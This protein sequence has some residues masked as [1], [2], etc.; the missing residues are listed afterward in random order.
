MNNVA[1][2]L[3]LAL[4]LVHV[5]V[6]A[7]ARPPPTR[8]PTPPPPPP[9]PAA[10]AANCFLLTAS[11]SCPEFAGKSKGSYR[12]APQ[13]N[14]RN[15]TEF[16]AF[17]AAN[18]PTAPPF[19]P[20]FRQQYSCPT[21]D[22]TGL[23]YSKTFTCGLLVSA[24]T[25]ACNP[26]V[27]VKQVCM[28][29][30]RFTVQSY[31]AIFNNTAFCPAGT[32]R[33]LQA[34]FTAYA[35]SLTRNDPTT[36][37]VI[38]LKSELPMCGWSSKG[39]V[40]NYCTGPGS[41]DPCCVE[42]KLAGNIVNPALT[43][44][45]TTAIV[46]PA[47]TTLSDMAATSTAQAAGTAPAIPLI[48]GMQPVQLG[49][50]IAVAGVVLSLVV[51]AVFTVVRARSAK[52]DNDDR[53]GELGG[54]YFSGPDGFQNK[55][56]RGPP[57][58]MDGPRGRGPAPMPKPPPPQPAAVA[59]KGRPPM[60]GGGDRG[61]RGGPK[62][63]TMEVAYEYIPHLDDEIELRPGDRVLVKAKFDD[64]W[65]TGVN[66]DSREEGSFP[67]DCLVPVRSGGGGGEAPKT[68]W[69]WATSAIGGGSGG[70]PAASQPAP[71]AAEPPRNKYGWATNGS[72]QQQQQQP[73]QQRGQ[74]YQG[75]Y[76]GNG[77]NGG[78]GGYRGNARHRA[79]SLYYSRD[80]GRY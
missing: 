56:G 73:P 68:M 24:A 39:E 34:P 27:D 15:L 10:P 13:A 61:D 55:G 7:Q 63:E 6:D 49:A 16:D 50:M 23:R 3:V 54:R 46:D 22:G 78:N 40:Y 29:S 58:P 71:P 41:N 79:S 17:V 75:G 5:G 30:A 25:P 48:A 80:G 64:G 47:T 18:D 66:L 32:P 11:T 53:N 59:A 4:S 36:N 77:G 9:P 60:G 44:T 2:A 67:M 1:A 26:G 38:A 74:P 19:V 51:G 33:A 52:A 72:P 35:S 21:W 37:C 28:L 45:T 14:F 8:S 70:A 31:N 20:F 62:G 42:A 69:E 65:A 12:V 43:E 76:S 57:P